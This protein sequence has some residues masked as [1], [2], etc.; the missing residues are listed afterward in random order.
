MYTGLLHLHRLIAYIALILI[1]IA[2]MKALFGF[3]NKKEF[4]EGDRKLGLFSLITAHTQLLLGLGLLFMGPYGKMLGKMGEV[5]K[6]APLR[7][8]VI[9]H[10]LTM[11]IAVILITVGYSKSKK[12][13]ASTA[14]F[15]TMAL[16]FLLA[17]ALILSRIPWDRLV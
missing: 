13:D 8:F 2:T 17:F 7:F 5:M 16:F 15:K 9:E 1:F 3:L 11:I 12:A 14:K 4:T 10:P 6:N